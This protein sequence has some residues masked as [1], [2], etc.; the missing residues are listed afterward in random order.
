MRK[1]G[2]TEA[3]KFYSEQGTIMGRRSILHV[4]IHDEEIFVGG[5]VTPLVEALMKLPG[6]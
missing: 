6:V 3:A 5:R 4:E 1:H 2:L